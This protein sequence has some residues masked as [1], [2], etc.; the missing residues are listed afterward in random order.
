MI[1]SGKCAV[2]C[3]YCFRR[4][5]PYQQNNPGRAQWQQAF[6][7]LNANQ[8]VQ[9]VIFSGGDPLSAPDR[10]LA[11]LSEQLAAM[12]HL[13]RL[14]I[15]S[16]LPVVIPDRIDDGLINWLEKSPLKIQLVLHINHPNEITAELEKAIARLRPLGIHTLNQSVLLKDINDDMETLKALQEK[17]FDAGILPYYLFTLDPVEGATHFD[18]PRQRAVQLINQLRAALP[19]YL[20][21]RLAAEIPGQPNKTLLG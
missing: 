3:R 19:G 9:E 16:R 8:D 12:T 5:F 6:D 21:P 7:Y 11:W 10:H 2:H 13:K 15:H 1:V 18:V 20:V 4:N 14:R 17:A